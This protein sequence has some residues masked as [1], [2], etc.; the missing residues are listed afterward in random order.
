MGVIDPTF[1]QI[2]SGNTRILK[3]SGKV[4]DI[5]NVFKQNRVDK[6]LGLLEPNSKYGV[7][8]SNTSSSTN[9]PANWSTD[10]T[11]KTK[12]TASSSED[13]QGWNH[14]NIARAEEGT[15]FYFRQNIS[16]S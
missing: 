3:M 15:T 16:K 7:V 5:L 2:K 14:C 1:I 6:A 11:E 8:S 10:A 12:Y 13:S 4:K 9:P